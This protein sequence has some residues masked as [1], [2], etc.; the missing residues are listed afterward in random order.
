[1]NLVIWFVI[2][3][4]AAFPIGLLGCWVYSLFLVGGRTRLGLLIL[5]SVSALLMF[6][7]WGDRVLN[8]FGLAWRQWFY[9]LLLVAAW[10]AVLTLGI[11]VAR[12]LRS[13]ARFIAVLCLVV[14]VLIGTPASFFAAVFRSNE[15]VG[16]WEGQTVIKVQV[17]MH[18]GDVALCQYYGPFVRGDDWLE[19][20]GSG[21][22]EAEEVFP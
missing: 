11:L 21:F 1:M 5:G 13:K 2:F 20:D 14:F 7:L 3:L 22:I 16:T 6:L 19:W 17:G 10:G 8:C 4:V 9:L 12:F 15:S 18:W